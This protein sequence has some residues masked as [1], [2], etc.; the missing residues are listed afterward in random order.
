MIVYK[1]I[2]YRNL[3]EQVEKNKQ[4]IAEHYARDRV[5]ENYGIKVVAT[6]NDVS[7]LP[8][9]LSYNGDYGDAY[10]VGNEP[11]YTF[12]IFTRP[13]QAVGQLDNRWLDLG[14]LAIPGPQGEQGEQ[15]IMG[16]EGKSNKWFTGENEPYGALEGDLWLRNDGNVYQYTFINNGLV[17]VLKSNVRGPQGIQGERGPQGVQ[18]IQGPIGPVGPIGLPGNAITIV[19]T[20]TN[21]SQLPTPSETIRNNGYLYVEDNNNYLYFITGTDTL[22]WE[23]ISFSNA[24]IVTV[25]GQP[26]TEFDSDTKVN[27]IS[28]ANVLYATDNTGN[29]TSMEYSEAE[30]PDTI[31]KRDAEGHI[32]ATEPEHNEN[33]ATKGYVDTKYNEEM[34][35]R[36][37]ED[38]L[39]D[40]RIQ[41]VGN[42]ILNPNLLINGDFQ[43]N[44]RNRTVYNTVGYCVDRWYILSGGISVTPDATQGLKIEYTGNSWAIVVQDVDRDLKDG[45]YTLSISVD[46]RQYQ[47]QVNLTKTMGNVDIPILNF[48][49]ARVS[50][51]NVTNRYGVQFIAAT[52]SWSGSVHY[53]NW[54]KL[55]YGDYAT[56][57]VPKSYSEELF[58][59]QYYYQKVRVQDGTTASTATVFYPTASLARTMRIGS[60]TTGVKFTEST[61]GT[62]NVRGQGQNYASGFTVALNAM[63]SNSIGLVVSFS[64]NTLTSQYV[65]YL[66]N[67]EVILDCE[68]R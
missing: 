14:E 40:T 51:G 57:F 68:L 38:Q 58:D 26:V 55:E 66:V 9:P 37:A 24:S 16:P 45:I 25:N 46:G 42:R 2:E 31:V 56:P 12:Y 60:G 28:E 34:L 17:W 3:I 7:Q 44:Q 15:G 23:R 54:I 41:N 1:G 50:Y 13:N 8:D 32:S 59:C 67:C 27:K 43:I 5:L 48:G 19:G 64:T 20:I 11:P 52:G 30:V 65:Y 62:S 35:A 53:V 22:I 47:K 10:A 4:D 21:T 36:Q 49:S 18:G 39:L 63:Y 29:D 33:V 61:A 6:I